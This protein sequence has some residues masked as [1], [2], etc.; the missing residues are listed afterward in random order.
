MSAY[1]RDLPLI[2]IGGWRTKAACADRVSELLWDD[3]VE[4]ETD[5]QREA[6]HSKGKAVCNRQCTV[7]AQC[8]E[9]VD[10][11]IDEGIRGGHKLPT[12]GVQHTAEE[13]ELAK[14]LRS[15]WPLDQAARAV[16]RPPGDEKAS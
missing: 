15:G 2:R 11:R 12:H 6:R 9:E 4:G 16:A 1:R 5:E 10:W 7:R 13:A 14:L 3:R 8:S